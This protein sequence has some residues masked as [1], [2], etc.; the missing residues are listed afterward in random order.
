[1]SRD[2]LEEKGVLVDFLKIYFGFMSIALRKKSRN[3][4]RFLKTTLFNGHRFSHREIVYIYF[5]CQQ[6]NFRANYN[7]SES[8]LL[9]KS[10]YI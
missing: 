10:H 1:M 5:N 7:D 4:S 8:G 3:F 2:N 6:S 9:F